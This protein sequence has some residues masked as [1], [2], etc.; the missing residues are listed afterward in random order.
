VQIRQVFRLSLEAMFHW[1]LIQLDA[2][3]RSTMSLVRRFLK[4]SGDAASTDRWFKEAR[5]KV[6]SPPDWIET[7]EFNLAE[8]KRIERLP[9]LIRK[10]LA[11]ALIEAPQK[12]GTERHDRLPLARANREAYQYANRPPENFLMHVFESWMFGQHVYWAVGRGLADA[13]AQDKTILRLKVIYEDRGWT[14]A[15]GVSASS[16]NAPNATPDR[17]ETALSLLREA[18]AIA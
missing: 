4:Q 10:A 2:R 6:L 9:R 5:G 13:R 8:Q 14:L 1:S 17:L 7:L 12:A 15:P 16:S 11:A 18:G 3:E